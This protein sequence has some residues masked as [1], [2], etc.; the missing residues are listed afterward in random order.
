M[1]PINH[2]TAIIR[3]RLTAV[4]CSISR[5]SAGVGAVAAAQLRGA[6][7]LAAVLGT[8]LFLSVQPNRYVRCQLGFTGCSRTNDEKWA[9]HV[10][11]VVEVLVPST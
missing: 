11:T 10:A 4:A 1:P 8:T 5:L 3:E 6:Q 9:R 2:P 7:Y